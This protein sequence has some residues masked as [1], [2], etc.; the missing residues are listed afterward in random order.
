LF[1]VTVTFLGLSEDVS[2]ELFVC[3]CLFKEGDEELQKKA[4]RRCGRKQ[5]DEEKTNEKPV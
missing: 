3:V 1:A 2:E 5:M 4:S